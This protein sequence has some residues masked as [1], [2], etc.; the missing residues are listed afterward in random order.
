M[1]IF[2]SLPTLL[3]IENHVDSEYYRMYVWPSLFFER[4]SIAILAA[5]FTPSDCLRF[6]EIFYSSGVMYKCFALLL[7]TDCFTGGLC[8]CP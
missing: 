1:E 6:S 5:L 4:K 8:C 2:S 7:A 3:I